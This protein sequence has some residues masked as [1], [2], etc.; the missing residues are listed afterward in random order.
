[1]AFPILIFNMKTISF[2]TLKFY[3][4]KVVHQEISDDENKKA[5]V[6]AKPLKIC[7]DSQDGRIKVDLF[8]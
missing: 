1:M 8:I 4:R 2:S 7:K 3:G 6:A 5:S